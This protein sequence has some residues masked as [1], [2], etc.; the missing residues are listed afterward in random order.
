MLCWQRGKPLIRAKQC[1]VC[2]STHHPNTDPA[3]ILAAYKAKLSTETY[4]P[5]KASCHTTL[6]AWQQLQLRTKNPLADQVACTWLLPPKLTDSGRESDARNHDKFLVANRLHNK[7]SFPFLLQKVS[8]GAHQ[9]VV[10]FPDL[11]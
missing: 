9:I 11:Y 5:N 10:F 3:D 6:K 1:R 7:R 8:L 2:S 4:Q